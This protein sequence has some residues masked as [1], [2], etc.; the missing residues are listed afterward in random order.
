MANKRV[1]ELAQ[2]S[3]GDLNSSDLLLLSDVS[4]QESKKLTLGDL[5]SYILTDGNLSG[6]F[7]GTASWS[8]NSKTASY[9][10]SVT[11]ASYAITASY[12][13]NGGSGGSTVSASWASSSLSSSFA[14]SASY[15][16]TVTS[17]ATASFA[18]SSRFADSASFVIYTGGNNGT[19]FQ[20]INATLA[21]TATS[22]TTASFAQSASFAR[23]A[24]FA[25]SASF[26]ANAGS[27]IS[28]SFA[29]FALSA[30]VGISTNFQSSASWA[31][32]SLSASF[33]DSAVDAQTAITA[34]YVLPN[35]SLQQYGVFLATTHSNYRSQLDKVDIDPFLNIAATASIEVVGT[36]VAPYTSSIPLNES[37]TLYAL[38]RGTGITYTV[39]STPI[40]V[41]IQGQFSSITASINGNLTGTIT[42]S[43]TGSVSGSFSGSISGSDASGALTASLLGPINATYNGSLLGSVTGS[44]STLLSG[45]MKFPFIL[46][47]QLYLETGSYMFFI[48]ASTSKIFIEPT[49]TSRFSI[50]SNIGQF[51]VTA[52]E[53]INLTTTN[54][55]DLIA[56]SSSAGGPFTNTAVNIVTSASAGDTITEIDISGVSGIRYIWTLEGLTSIKS[57]SNI[58][59]NDIQG[60]PISIVTMSLQNGNLNSLYTLATTSASILNVFNN[61][62]AALPTLP[63][64]MSY[65]NC[66]SNPILS[67]PSTIPFGV[68]ELYASNTSITT[69]PNTFSD[70]IVS[71]SFAS[72]TNLNLWLTAL[73][74]SLS[75]FDVSNCP[76]LTALPTIPSNVRS[77]SIS[78]DSFTDVAQDNICSN[79]VT[80]GLLSGSLNLLGNSSLLPITLTRIATLQ[81]RAWT[82]SY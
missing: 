58:F 53:V 72:N 47:G 7:F 76:Q 43:V 19:I 74:T 68:T 30:S 15:A 9:I 27:S 41:N 36:M 38:N 57:N 8:E 33:A 35:L 40:Y 45:S 73:P 34:S 31:S 66:S 3:T 80:N 56:F 2:I 28:S 23:S 77:L 64:T 26:T 63:S 55:S 12:A 78:G 44:V 29:S 42:G 32:Q 71:M 24:S 65:I 69:P 22:A 20:A 48:S 13:L 16:Q 51:G 82:V 4:A 25:Q 59:V 21:T 1:S 10:A 52:G 70:T 54:P 37:V 18:T 11:T 49:R 61:Q 75:S 67:L 60:M 46:M 62:L 39:D 79:L 50:S 5:N 17:A 14:R 6:S 81:S